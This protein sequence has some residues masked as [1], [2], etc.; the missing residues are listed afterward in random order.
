M[1]SGS[2]ARP[3]RTFQRTIGA[4]ALVAGAACT[5]ATAPSQTWIRIEP[6]RALY[7]PGDTVIL[8]VRNIT[9]TILSYTTCGSELQ[10]LAGDRW[11]D[12]GVTDV[13]CGDN[14]ARL[15]V[16]ASVDSFAGVL[17]DSLTTGTYRYQIPSA[18]PEPGTAVLPA[19]AL[20][21]APFLVQRQ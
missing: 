20:S 2:C 12:I 9:A 14:A 21:S 10:R 13:N 3:V 1:S 4:V 15:D 17:A 6:T 5:D 8:T 18:R 11:T 16:G 19:S 7:S